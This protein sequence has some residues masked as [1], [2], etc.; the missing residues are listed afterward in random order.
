MS[1]R[2]VTFFFPSCATPL[3]IP[4]SCAYFQNLSYCTDLWLNP[5]L[6]CLIPAAL[7]DW[8]GLLRASFIHEQALHGTSLAVPLRTPPVDRGTPA[9]LRQAE[10][11]GETF[12]LPLP[13]PAHPSA[14]IRREM[15]QCLML[16][17]VNEALWY[18]RRGSWS[19]KLSYS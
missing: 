7:K 15:G 1:H 5:V 4:R 12:K 16:F 11:D 19:D 18:C 9:P 2:R 13:P 17:N 10:R 14:N 3:C 6:T 8:P